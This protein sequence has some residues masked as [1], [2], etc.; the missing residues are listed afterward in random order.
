MEELGEMQGLKQQEYFECE[1][2]GATV[3]GASGGW[4]AEE[5]P[6]GKK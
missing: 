3:L 6:F 1:G 2:T 4:R 5:R